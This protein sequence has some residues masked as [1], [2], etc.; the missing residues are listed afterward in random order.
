MAIVRELRETEWQDYQGDRQWAESVYATN[1][2]VSM[3]I[4]MQR[5]A[6]PQR[7]L[8]SSEPWC[9]HVIGT[10]DSE[11]PRDEVVEIHNGR[12]GSENINK[13]LK[14]GYDCDWSPSHDFTMNEGYFLL[15]VLGY[16]VMG[17]MKCFYLQKTQMSWQ[18]KKL[19]YWFINTCGRIIKTGRRYYCTLLNVCDETYALFEQCQCRMRESW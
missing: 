12:M 16:S 10:N 19:R 6:N 5:W 11:R 14:G 17:L 8:F 4:I 18:I 1:E 7:D 3:R 2:G 13:E 9:Y 15:G